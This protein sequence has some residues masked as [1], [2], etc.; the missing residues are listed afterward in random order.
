MRPTSPTAPPTPQH[1]RARRLAFQFRRDGVLIGEYSTLILAGAPDP[2]IDR[3]CI[4]SSR[5]LP[6]REIAKGSS[7][8]GF[9]PNIT[10]SSTRRINVIDRA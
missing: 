10:N 8:L 5:P 3:A 4:M 6:I 9:P 2:Q 7:A 1:R